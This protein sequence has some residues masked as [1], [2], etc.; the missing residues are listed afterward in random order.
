MQ[1]FGWL[2]HILI[3]VENLNEMVTGKLGQC[4]VNPREIILNGR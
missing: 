4:I 3:E 2:S 1:D